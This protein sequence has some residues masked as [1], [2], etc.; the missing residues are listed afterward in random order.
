MIEP[1][2]DDVLRRHLGRVE[3]PRELWGRIQDSQTRVP[4][5]RLFAIAAA[6]VVMMVAFHPREKRTVEIQFRLP[7]HNLTL[8]VPKN[9]AAQEALNAACVLC[10]PG[11]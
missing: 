10:H 7:E 5:P 3:A 6:A 2:M 4:V 9:M 8:R 11:V 1:R